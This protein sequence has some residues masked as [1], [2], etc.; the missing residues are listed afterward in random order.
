[1]ETGFAT[2]QVSQFLKQHREDEELKKLYEEKKKDGDASQVK[3]VDL[4][5]IIS[6]N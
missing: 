1:M 4:Q 2:E 3:V 5:W 6:I